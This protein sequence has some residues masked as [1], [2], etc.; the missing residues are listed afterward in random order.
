MSNQCTTL[1][2]SIHYCEGKPVPAGIRR[3]IW[4]TAK[5]NIAEWPALP[6]DELGRVTSDVLAGAF[7]MKADKVFYGIDV[8]TEKSG[9][10][11]EAQGE[12]PNQTQLNKLTGVLPDVDEVASM[13]AAYINNCDCVF[14][15]EDIPGKY[16]VIGNDAWE[17]KGTVAQDL[18]QG[19]A[20]NASTTINIEHTDY[21]PAPFYEGPIETDEGTINPQGSGSGSGSGSQA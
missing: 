9:V 6:K 12:K 11:S 7:V 14:I 8:L 19:A 15:F 1:Q 21:V 13:A 3:R 5:S 18:G 17:G 2:G 4:Y 20:G 16:R 10:T